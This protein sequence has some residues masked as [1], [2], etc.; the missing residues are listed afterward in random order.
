MDKLIEQ[1]GPGYTGWGSGSSGTETAFQLSS[2]TVAGLRSG[3][4]SPRAY[5]VGEAPTWRAN[6]TLNVL[7]EP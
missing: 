2:S 4:S 5:V 6:A 3:R 7:E 1:H